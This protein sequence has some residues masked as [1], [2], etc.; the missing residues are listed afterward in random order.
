MP[1]ENV[2]GGSD[3]PKIGAKQAVA[4]KRAGASV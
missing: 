3:V 4:A 2:V 1:P